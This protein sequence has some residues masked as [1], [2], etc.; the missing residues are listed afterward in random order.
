MRCR[1]TPYDCG[2]FR[3]STPKAGLEVLLN[4]PPL[5]LYLQY[6]ISRS[7]VRL[8]DSLRGPLYPDGSIG[9]LAAARELFLASGADLEQQ[10]RIAETQVKNHFTVMK[11]SF[12]SGKVPTEVDRPQVFTDGS[13]LRDGSVGTGIHVRLNGQVVVESSSYLGSTATVFQ[14]E[15]MAIAQAAEGFEEKLADTPDLPNA[16]TVY[17][18]SQAA[19]A[20]LHKELVVSEMVRQCKE[21]LNRLGS[22]AS[23]RLRWV[24]GHAHSDGNQRADELARRT[25][26]CRRP[27]TD[28]APPT[29]KAHFDMVLKDHMAESWSQRWRSLPAS[30]ARQARLWFPTPCPRK[31]KKLL[32]MGREKFSAIVRWLTGH[33]FLRLQNHR[34]GMSDTPTCRG[35]GEA[36]ERAD[37]VLLQCDSY[38]QERMD[39]SLTTNID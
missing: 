10:D 11:S 30:F 25:A 16:L 7:Y 12:Y 26:G 20:A 6:E 27:R 19:L 4:V 1:R 29:P 24:K 34:A 18:D 28:S 35:C 14:A 5:D 15:L 39:S 3:R 2:H 22:F 37:H 31:S 23:V 21:K 38:F 33:A 36:D 17:T 9:H 8:R 32:A 13:K